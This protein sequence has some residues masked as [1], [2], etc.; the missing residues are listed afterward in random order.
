MAT[1]RFAEIWAGTLREEAVAAPPVPAPAP[2]PP[3]EPILMRDPTDVRLL[4]VIPGE[5]FALHCRFCTGTGRLPNGLG[6]DLAILGFH[7]R[8]CELCAGKGVLRLVSSDLP[9]NCGPCQ[10]T[11]RRLGIDRR[12]PTCQGFGVLAL[13]GTLARVDP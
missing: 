9:V 5:S 6:D 8:P 12:C 13:T 11:G 10:G 2:A 1:S 4:Q 7:D 3:P